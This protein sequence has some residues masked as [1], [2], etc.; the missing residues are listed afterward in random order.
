MFNDLNTFIEFIEYLIVSSVYYFAGNRFMLRKLLILYGIILFSS[1]QAEPGNETVYQLKG[2][3]VKVH[4]FADSGAQSVG[5]GVVIAENLVATNCHV[6]ANSNGVNIGAAGESFSPVGV[7]EDWRHDVCILRF[8]YLPLKPVT[9]GDSDTIEYEQSVFSIGFPGGSPKP[10]T[11]YGKVK[12]LYPLDDASIIRT[13]AAF[14]EG[15]SGSPLMDD[16]GKLLGLSTF[17]SPGKNSFYY[18]VP[19]K[20]VKQ[21]LDS[22]ENKLVG[23]AGTPFWDAPEES[24]PYLMR[25]VLPLQ[26]SE[27]DALN[28]IAQSWTQAEPNSAEAH[29][30]LGLAEN[31]LGDTTA[32]TKEYQ[33][34]LKLNPRHSASILALAKIAQYNDNTSQFQ[35]LSLQLKTLDS[36]AFDSLNAPNDPH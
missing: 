31:R 4:A 26:N 29:Y 33:Q 20:W 18:S 3:I 30:Y 6:I 2:S 34:A 32:A 35:A 9:L 10:L 8:M 21:L 1:V 14:I 25:V 24:R 7:R 13:S 15:S 22:P 11:T 16:Q 27:W 12:A 28:I 5:T 23:K 19:V 36:N 17:K